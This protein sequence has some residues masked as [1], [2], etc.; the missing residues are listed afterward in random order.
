MDGVKKS[1]PYHRG[2]FR[3]INIIGETEKEIL[4]EYGVI[5]K[6]SGMYSWGRTKLKTYTE[7]EMLDEIYVAENCHLLAEK[8]RRA[9]ADILRQI[10]N[11]FLSNGV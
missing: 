5:N 8:T 10:E 1:S 7:Q 4:C 11:V 2:Y 3:T 6:K 9:T